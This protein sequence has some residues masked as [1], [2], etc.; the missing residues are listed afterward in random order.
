MQNRFYSNSSD[1]FNKAE[2]TFVT[3]YDFFEAV[4]Y[5]K[6]SKIHDDGTECSSSTVCGVLYVIS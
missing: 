3:A 4:G 6:S 5:L 1:D 2:G